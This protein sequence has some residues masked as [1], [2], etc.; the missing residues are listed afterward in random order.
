MPGR[1][2]GFWS[3]SK[4]EMSFFGRLTLMNVQV[5]TA[6]ARVVR[7]RTRLFSSGWKGGGEEERAGL[8]SRR[9]WN[10][11]GRKCIEMNFM[12]FSTKSFAVSL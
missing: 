6:S 7:R 4:T 12:Q 5:R 3:D 10:Q 8:S 1:S 2:E 9:A 11:F